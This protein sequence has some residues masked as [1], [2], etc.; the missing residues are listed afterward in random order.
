MYGISE[1]YI[2][3]VDGMYP[4]DSSNVALS[5]GIHFTNIII[6]KIHRNIVRKITKKSREYGRPVYKRLCV[7]RTNFE[8]G[9]FCEDRRDAK[10]TLLRNGK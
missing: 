7:I 2:V 6:T 1:I 5:H 4:I 8:E 3:D 9:V 10:V